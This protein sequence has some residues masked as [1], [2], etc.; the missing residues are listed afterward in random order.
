MICSDSFRS[1]AVSTSV[2]KAGESVSPHGVRLPNA[3][4]YQLSKSM[5]PVFEVRLPSCVVDPVAR[6]RAGTHDARVRVTVRSRW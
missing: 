2:T 4:R 3:R 6:E 5:L 1:S